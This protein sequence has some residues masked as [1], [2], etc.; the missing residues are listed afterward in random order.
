[1]TQEPSTQRRRAGSEGASYTKRIMD[2][3]TGRRVELEWSAE[4]LAEEMASVGVPWTRDAVSNLETGRRKHLAVHELLALA[5]V[6]DIPNPVDLLVP[7]GSARAEMAF[8]VT[9][10]ITANAKAV[11]AWF[12][13]ETGPLRFYLATAAGRAEAEYAKSIR[14]AV[15]LMWRIEGPVAGKTQEEVTDAILEGLRERRGGTVALPDAG[16]LVSPYP[17]TGEDDG[18]GEG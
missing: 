1:M 4:R 9:P 11:R 12:G 10:E 8:P 16:W 5:W 13:G 15:A 7:H 17:L 6:L 14:D 2:A 3:V 18:D